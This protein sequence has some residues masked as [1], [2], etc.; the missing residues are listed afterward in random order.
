ML[1]Y[2]TFVLTQLV[3]TKKNAVSFSHHTLY[4]LF[5]DGFLKQPPLFSVE[6]LSHPNL[7]AE[8]FFEKFVYLKR[9]TL[10][11]FFI[12]NAIDNPT[13][14]TKAHSLRRLNRNVSFIKLINYLTKSGKREKYSKIFFHS[15]N[16]F[17]QQSSSRLFNATNFPR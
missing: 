17:F 9:S 8:Y 10:I 5:K 15:L 1:L 7:S 16:F 4:S 11:H 3:F 13:C 14:F 2:K 12:E 6:S